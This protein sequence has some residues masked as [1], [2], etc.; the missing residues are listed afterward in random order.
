MKFCSKCAGKL[1]VK[2]PS[3]DTRERHVCDNCD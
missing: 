2:I 1:T 3:D